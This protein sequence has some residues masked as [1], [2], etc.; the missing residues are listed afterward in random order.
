MPTKECNQC[1]RTCTAG[2]TRTFTAG[3]ETVKINNHFI[4]PGQVKITRR[5]MLAEAALAHPQS[6][7]DALSALPFKVNLDF[8]LR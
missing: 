7:H 5:V 4:C 3:K 1:Q 8:Y 6:M 2:I